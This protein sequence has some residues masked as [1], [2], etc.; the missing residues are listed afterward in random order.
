MPAPNIEAQVNSSTGAISTHEEHVDAERLVED[1]RSI[2]RV[3]TR[4]AMD[5]LQKRE[6]STRPPY[7]LLN[8][9]LFQQIRA[10]CRFDLQRKFLR[11][12]QIA[13][14]LN[15][16]IVPNKWKLKLDYLIAVAKQKQ[17]DLDPVHGCI[18]LFEKDLEGIETTVSK[19]RKE[20]RESRRVCPS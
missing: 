20:L 14:G 1:L 3:L 4:I 2:K 19:V 18:Q 11:L 12:R 6:P 5:L 15:Q 10:A 17:P 9:E 16:G 8:E 13:D 7:A